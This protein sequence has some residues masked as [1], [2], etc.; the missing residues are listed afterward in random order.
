MRSFEFVRCQWSP[1]PGTPTVRGLHRQTYQGVPE[2][3]H[4]AVGVVI[5]NLELE[6][7]RKDTRHKIDIG[8]G[9]QNSIPYIL[10]GVVLRSTPGC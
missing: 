7:M 10:F 1:L 4:F 6:G 8:S 9:N 3:L 5:V 2:V